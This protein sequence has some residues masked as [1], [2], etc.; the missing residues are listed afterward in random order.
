LGNSPNSRIRR[1][2]GHFIEIIEM[3][4]DE[5]TDMSRRFYISMVMCMAAILAGS[6]AERRAERT[7]DTRPSNTP[8]ALL[9]MDQGAQAIVAAAPEARWPQVDRYIQAMENAW[10]DYEHPAVSTKDELR[11]PWERELGGNVDAAMD[12]LRQ[13]AATRNAAATTKAA[14]DVD[15]AVLNLFEFYQT[16]VT[17]AISAPPTE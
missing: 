4:R 6:C 7:Y 15:T 3:C 5:G 12:R 17:Q 16:T 11:Q 10:T 13:A 9:Q 1:K 8:S 14:N 2:G